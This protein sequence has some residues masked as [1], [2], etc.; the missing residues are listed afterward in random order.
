[1]SENLPNQSRR[2]DEMFDIKESR[3]STPRCYALARG[4]LET[5]DAEAEMVEV[6]QQMRSF[7]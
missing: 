7:L 1:M 6:E 4:I 3:M 5:P 2:L